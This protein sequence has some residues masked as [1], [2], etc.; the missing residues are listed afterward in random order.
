M[1]EYKPTE[2]DL[3]F[4]RKLSALSTEDALRELGCDVDGEKEHAKNVKSFD[5]IR[6]S[7]GRFGKCFLDY[8]KEYYEWK[9]P[10]MIYDGEL[11]EIA[12]IRDEEAEEEWTK[13]YE[14][15]RCKE[16]KTF[17]EIVRQNQTAK[18]IADET[19]LNEIIYQPI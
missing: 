14:Q 1:D 4:A 7:L 6:A 11:E 5:E 13:I 19:V 15:N 9:L 18:N 3:E 10:L 12:R 8:V 16:S 17:L 2:E